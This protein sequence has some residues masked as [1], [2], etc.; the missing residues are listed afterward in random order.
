MLTCC[1]GNLGEH[2]GDL[3][4][5]AHFP[6]KRCKTKIALGL[7]NGACSTEGKKVLCF[8]TILNTDWSV[9]ERGGRDYKL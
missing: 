7:Q 2:L 9:L 5:E 6:R 8:D 1:E 4:R 3:C